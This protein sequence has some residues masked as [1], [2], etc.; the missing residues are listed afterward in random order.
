DGTP[1]SL[2]QGLVEAQL[3]GKIGSKLKLTVMREGF[4]VPREVTLTR[5]ALPTQAV[6]IAWHGPFLHVQLHIFSEGTA[7]SVARAIADANASKTVKGIILDLRNNPGGLLHQ[8]AEVVDLFVAE[9]LIVSTE[10]RD[11][12]VLESLY[13]KKGGAFEKIPLAVLVNGMS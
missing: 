12:A 8:A 10:G 3:R 2:Q 1:V 7:R 4:L 5:R 9:G 13:A 6:S 11:G